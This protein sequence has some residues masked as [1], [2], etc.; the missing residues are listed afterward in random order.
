MVFSI[1]GKCVKVELVLLKL[2]SDSCFMLLLLKFEMVY[3]MRNIHIGGF[4]F[5]IF[6]I[7]SCGRSEKFPDYVTAHVDIDNVKFTE[8]TDYFFSGQ[9]SGREQESKYF[10]VLDS[11]LAL[12]QMYLHKNE[13]FDMGLFR[14]MWSRFK[15]RTENIRF[16][17]NAA[18]KWFE[19]TGF[20]FELSGNAVHAEELERISRT[21]FSYLAPDTRNPMILPYVFTKEVDHIHVNL[22][23]PAE[24]GYT[25]SLGGGVKIRQETD[26]PG[27]GKVR[28]IFSMETKQ[29]IELYVRIPTW[30]ESASVTVKGVKYV[31]P[32]GNYCKIAKKWKEGDEVE[33]EFPPEN[34][35]DYLKL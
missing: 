21:H 31:A 12:K 13:G 20:L 26:Y 2:N 28:L 1:F 33:I 9:Y 29:Y 35:P 23:L 17:E 14:E 8:S 16:N 4:V 27:S 7:V 24:I 18:K 15:G 32:P 11:L 6:I 5:I 10:P 30:A 22:F 19:V 25:H 3:R 34:M